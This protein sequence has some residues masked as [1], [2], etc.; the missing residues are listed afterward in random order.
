VKAAAIIV[1]RVGAAAG[2]IASGL[3]RLIDRHVNAWRLIEPHDHPQGQHGQGTV[4][5]EAHGPDEQRRT[6]ENPSPDIQQPSFITG[7]G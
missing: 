5:R 1:N 7:L 3:R 4:D 2:A 6:H